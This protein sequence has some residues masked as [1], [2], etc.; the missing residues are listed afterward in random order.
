MRSVTLRFG[1]AF[2]L[3]APLALT[4]GDEFGFRAV[5]GSEVTATLERRYEWVLRSITHHYRDK[6]V[7]LTSF[8]PSLRLTGEHGARWCDRW[9][10]V[11]D[12]QPETY[13]RTI[14]SMESLIDGNWTLDSSTG[15]DQPA[16]IVGKVL[17]AELQAQHG[18]DGWEFEVLSPNRVKDADCDGLA[19]AVGWSGVL[20]G[21]PI[22]EGAR[23]YPTGE[24]L[25]ELLRPLGRPRMT[26]ES[27]LGVYPRGYALLGRVL[28]PAEM[29]EFSDELVAVQ[30][31][32]SEEGVAQLDVSLMCGEW[33]DLADR[34]LRQS[35]DHGIYERTSALL[36]CATIEIDLEGDG[37]LLWSTDES[38]P[39]SVELQGE[40]EV[41][42]TLE[43]GGWRDAS[44]VL[45]FEG[46]FSQ[47]LSFSYSQAETA[48]RRDPTSTGGGR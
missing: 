47:N 39:I 3:A 24:G 30:Y 10:S 44:W 20:P 2:L 42:L 38:R 9:E 41:E 13:R 45:E 6:E 15:N 31:K 17:G 18:D 19:G 7:D 37:L 28:D 22:A 35:K 16:R 8:W 36:E 21:A 1:T 11:R 23:W 5:Q 43:I 29:L 12:G 46:E 4:T 26:F 14:L 32:G 40:I 34:A 48:G 27:H 33:V 25:H